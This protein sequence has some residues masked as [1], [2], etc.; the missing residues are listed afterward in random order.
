MSSTFDLRLSLPPGS[1][2]HRSLMHKQVTF[3]DFVKSKYPE[4]AQARFLMFSDSDAGR[5]WCPAEY[6]EDGSLRPLGKPSFPEQDYEGWYPISGTTNELPVSL[7]V[8]D[9]GPP[10][11]IV[12]TASGF[13][14]GSSVSPSGSD[15]ER[16]S[17]EEVP[18]T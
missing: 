2:D 9:E 5:G 14:R 6:A 3:Q 10:I 8:D 11:L 12:P 15:T 4:L 17:R 13:G 7:F 16:P 1:P 18:G